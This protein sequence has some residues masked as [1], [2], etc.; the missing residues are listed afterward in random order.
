VSRPKDP[1]DIEW[2]ESPVTGGFDWDAL[3]FPIFLIVAVIAVIVVYVLG[4]V[5]S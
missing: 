5:P 4:G 3:L 2:W 1:L